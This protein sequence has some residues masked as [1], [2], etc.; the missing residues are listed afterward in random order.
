MS[1][2]KLYQEKKREIERDREAR[3]RQA[4]AAINCE[5]ISAA[6]VP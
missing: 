1:V 5:A 2:I 3:V 6:Q 4:I